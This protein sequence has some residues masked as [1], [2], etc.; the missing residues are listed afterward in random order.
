MLLDIQNLTIEVGQGATAKKIVAGAD[1]NINEREIVALVGGSGS[2][3]TST[4][5]AVLRLLAPGVNIT[6][7]KI[8]FQGQDILKY[9]QRQMRDLRAVEIS[10][11]FQDPLSAFNP[12]FTA[13]FQ[14]DEVFRFHTNFS[15]RNARQKT[16]ELLD[17]VGIA[18]PLRAYNSYPHQL[19]GGMRQRAMI[20]LALALNPRLIIADEPT[21]N[22]DVTL[23]A[24]IIDLFCKLRD[25]KGISIL[26]ITHDLGVV[27]RISER[28][29]VMSAGRVVE[30]G[31]TDSILLTP[32]HPY[33]RQLLEAVAI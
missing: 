28:V 4:G 22:L 19:S 24:R 27:R 16:I 10:M 20:A 18:D 11:V 14:I 30:S 25:E 5:L 2:G 15:S 26:L 9:S 21:S 13:G 23:Q 6:S 32:T 31:A 1:L 29:Y 3:K 33:T 12:V 7:G 17:T 8:M